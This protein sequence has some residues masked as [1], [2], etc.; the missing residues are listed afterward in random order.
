MLASGKSKEGLSLLSILDNTKS[1]LGRKLLRTWVLRP[2]LKESEIELR[3]QGV[4]LANAQ[5]EVCA[6][7][8]PNTHVH[9]HANTCL[10]RAHTLSIHT[11]K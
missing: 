8:L 3:T 5:M 2:L 9:A 4:I 1:P 7:D 6:D 11:R 10:H